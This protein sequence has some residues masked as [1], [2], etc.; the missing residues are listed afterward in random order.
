MKVEKYSL[1]SSTPRRSMWSGH[2]YTWTRFYLHKRSSLHLPL[3]PSLTSMIHN[4]NDDI[5]WL[6]T[7]SS[8]NFLS[9]IAINY[10]IFPSIS[11]QFRSPF[12]TFLSRCNFWHIGFCFCVLGFV[13]LWIFWLI[14]DAV[15]LRFLGFFPPILLGFFIPK[16]FWCCLLY[17]V[18]WLN[19]H[20]SG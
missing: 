7:V 13:F 4:N 20:F 1:K 2:P 9:S 11:L 5:T 15:L 14:H 8:G 12:P 18:F 19:W 16:F 3:L 10:H 17:S 6:S